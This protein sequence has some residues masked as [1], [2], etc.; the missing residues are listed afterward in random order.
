M[1]PR[2]ASVGRRRRQRERRAAGFVR[3]LT[4][5]AVAGGTLVAWLAATVQ[6]AD[7]QM[8]PAEMQRQLQQQMGGGGGSGGGG[9]PAPNRIG[10]SPI[11]L[12]SVRRILFGWWVLK[13]RNLSCMCKQFLLKPSTV[14]APPPSRPSLRDTMLPL[15]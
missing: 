9:A 2:R 5:R 3:R 15:P 7:G 12:G 1:L 11:S 6:I 8:D 4:R 10:K 14:R 13:Q